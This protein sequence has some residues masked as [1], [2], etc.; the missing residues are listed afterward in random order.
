MYNRPYYHGH[1]YPRAWDMDLNT[2]VFHP[3]LYHMF[4]IFLK[5]DVRIHTMT[6]QAFSTLL[7]DPLHILA[8]S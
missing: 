3:K 2:E 1:Y 7:C 5:P 8:I 4:S 6:R